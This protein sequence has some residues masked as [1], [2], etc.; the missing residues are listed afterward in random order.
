[1]GRTP[2]LLAKPG[3]VQNSLC[4]PVRSKTSLVRL[5]GSCG[6]RERQAFGLNGGIG[7]EDRREV[8]RANENDGRAPCA[9]PASRRRC[10]GVDAGDVSCQRGFVRIDEDLQTR[11][12]QRVRRWSSAEAGS[13]GCSSLQPPYHKAGL[14]QSL[15]KTAERPPS[16][17]RAGRR[18]SLGRRCVRARGGPALHGEVAGRAGICRPRRTVAARAQARGEQEEK[19]A[20][21]H[22]VRKDGT[23]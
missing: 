13:S 23:R 19:G 10:K 15:L 12:A 11:M 1:M 18:L 22:R 14:P 21:N 8:R 20:G 5:R 2:I 16:R 6:Y 7:H 4:G 9:G 3:D 17:A